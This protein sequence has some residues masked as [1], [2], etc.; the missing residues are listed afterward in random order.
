MDNCI[1]ASM[2][3]LAIPVLF[4]VII[5]LGNCVFVEL[6]FFTCEI[7]RDVQR[8]YTKLRSD[9]GVL[10]SPT[11]VTVFA[12]VYEVNLW[13]A[14]LNALYPGAFSSRGIEA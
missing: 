10:T 14:F 13:S 5:I 6:A 11:S 1:S 7:A 2:L 12:Y 9:V 3:G 4:G 8:E